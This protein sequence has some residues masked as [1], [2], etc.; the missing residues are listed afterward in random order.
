MNYRPAE[1]SV[2][3]QAAG[4]LSRGEFEYIELMNIDPSRPV[5]LEGVAF[6]GGIIFAGFDSTLPADALVLAP[7]ER[8][9]LVDTLAAF[10]FRHGSSGA[11]V[12]GEFAGSLSNDGEQI[13]L[14]DAGGGIIKD[15]VYNDV[16]PWPVAADGDGFSLVL[17]DPTSNPDHNDPLS[18]R[19]SVA[20]H[21]SPG[22]ADSIPF[23]GDPSVDEDGDGQDAFYE[24]ATGTSDADRSSFSLPSLSVDALDV[25]AVVDDYLMVEFNVNLAAVGVSYE[26][27]SCSDLLNWEA[28]RDGLVLVSTTNHGDGTATVKY[29]TAGSFSSASPR[30]FFR[31]KVSG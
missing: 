27:Q 20:L 12:A 17:V 31:L 3:E 29:R 8:V 24:Y 18:W 4:F 10:N 30:T 1:A 25:G 16:E 19:S 5:T 23:V 28:A 11:I 9:I 14:L 15:F 21:G 2:A 7:G 26:L 6:T 22:G 13:T